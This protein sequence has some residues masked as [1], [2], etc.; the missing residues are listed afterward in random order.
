M[1][2]SSWVVSS[3][4]F[5][6]NLLCGSS[7]PTPLPP[8]WPSEAAPGRVVERASEMNRP[9]PFNWGFQMVIHGLCHKFLTPL[10][11]VR[12]DPPWNPLSNVSEGA[13]IFWGMILL[14]M[15]TWPDNSK[16]GG[17]RKKLTFLFTKFWERYSVSSAFCPY[18]IRPLITT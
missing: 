16:T 11:L 18:S 15:V 10:S 12:V 6:N 8:R 7:S 17:E 1:K 13:V 4:V 14:G 9:R 2:K 3:E 5:R